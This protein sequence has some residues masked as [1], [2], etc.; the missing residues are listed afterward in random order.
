MDGI[1]VP[2]TG[3]KFIQRCEV[4]KMTVKL[5]LGAQLSQVVPGPVLT[6]EPTY[7]WITP[8]LLSESFM[9]R[10]MKVHAGPQQTVFKF[11]SQS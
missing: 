11:Q 1:R 9:V 3:K 7:F 10:T 6:S 5:T 4:G 8:H 2:F